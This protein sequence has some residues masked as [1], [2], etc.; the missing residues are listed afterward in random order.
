MTAVCTGILL[1]AGQST[2]FGTDKLL[3]PLPDGTPLVLASA[4]PLCAVLAHCIAVVGDPDGAVA[5]LLAEAGLQVIANP[6]ATAG[7]ASSVACGVTASAAARGW[8][9]ALADMPFVPAGVVRQVATRLVC[10]ADL[11]A[12]AWCGRRGHPVGFAARYGPALREL[13]GDHGARDILAAHHDT[14][15]LIDTADRGVIVDIDTP[16]SLAAA[17]TASR[18]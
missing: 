14:L 10:G 5:R 17:L 9:I 7:Q 18:Q 12:P 16:Q 2:R 4:R 8:I 15:E 13:R 6:R 11:V 1:A 3:Q